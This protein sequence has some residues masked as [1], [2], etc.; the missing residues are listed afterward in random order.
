[1]AQQHNEEMI[2]A[3]MTRY[4]RMTL[5]SQRQQLRSDAFTAAEWAE[6]NPILQLG[7][8][9]SEK[10]T[11]KIKI[12]DGVNAWNDLPYSGGS[13]IQVEEL[14]E[15]SEDELGK[16][17]Q[18]V[19][20]TGDSLTNGYFYKCTSAGSPAVYSWTRI[21]VQPV[22]TPAEIGAVTQT[23]AS[24]TLNS[25]D[26]SSHAQTKTVSGVTADNTVIVSPAAASASDYAA[27]EILCTAQS[28]NSLSF[29]CTTDPTSNIS[30]N[31][32]I[33]N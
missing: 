5:E 11:N 24:I 10:D 4:G 31:I 7:E 8:L 33:L 6:H 30:V 29:S 15:A 13:V 14:P 3:P 20:A 2:S 25:A 22:P 19:G 12:G 21:D 27:A 9:G 23:T 26:W 16:I 32:V 1:M 28:A 17:Y 18:Y